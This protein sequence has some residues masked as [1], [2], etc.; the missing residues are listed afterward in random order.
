LISSLIITTI[1]IQPWIS[2]PKHI[3]LQGQKYTFSIRYQKELYGLLG[4]ALL[5]R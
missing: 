1:L 3:A 2:L 5:Q 4:Q